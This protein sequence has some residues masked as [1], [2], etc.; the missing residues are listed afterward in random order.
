M[1]VVS[2]DFSEKLLRVVEADFTKAFCDL[3]LC[4]ETD[5]RKN[6]AFVRKGEA[7][8]A[9]Y[10][11]NGL[12]ISRKPP[13]QEKEL[14]SPGLQNNWLVKVSNKTEAGSFERFIA[15][16]LEH[17]PAVENGMLVFWDRTF[18]RMEFVLMKE[19]SGDE[20]L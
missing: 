5:I 18:G 12:Q 7:Y 2:Y 3:S 10:A 17:T 9:I 19:T 11:Q 20:W 13:L 15:W 16:H 14:I 6:W 8:L 1:A 4:D